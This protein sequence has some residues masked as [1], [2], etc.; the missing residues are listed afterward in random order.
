MRKEPSHYQFGAVIENDG[1]L[2]F[3]VWAPFVETVELNIL[4]PKAIRLP[5]TH[6]GY[7]V[8]VKKVNIDS[9]PIDYTFILDG[10]KER[11]DPA[12]FW[13]PK[14]I[15][16]PSRVWDPKVTTWNDQNWRGLNLKEMIIYE[17]H[18]GTFTP[19]G[20]FQGVINKIPHLKNL[21][22]NTIELMPVATFSGERN[23]GYDGVQLYAPQESYGGPEG[24]KKLVDA[25]HQNGIAVILD[26]VYNHV[27][28][29]GNYLEDFGPYFT[30]KYT[31]P[32]GKAINYDGEYSTFV[33]EF[34]IEN[35]IY[36][37]KQYHIDGLRLD[38]I[39][40][41]FDQSAYHVLEELRDRFKQVAEEEGRQAWLIAESDLNDPIHVKEQ[42]NGGYGLDGQWNDDF[43]HSVHAYLTGSRQ[44]YFEDF[45]TLENI[46]KAL[47]YGFVYDGVWSEYR[48]RIHGKSSVEIPGFRLVDFIQNHDQIA[49]ASH[50][51][52]LASILDKKRY[53]LA[54]TLL[55][56]SPSPPLLFMGQEW[57]TTTPFYFFTDFSDPD[58]QNAVKNGRLQEYSAHG[59]SEGFRDPGT[60]ET[61]QDSTLDW[62]WEYNDKNSEIFD[63]YKKLIAL[64]KEHPALNNCKKTLTHVKYS[65]ENQWMIIERS[66]IES[67]SCILFINFSEYTTTIP[68][69]EHVYKGKP[70]Y[71]TE[72]IHQQSELVS[73]ITLEPLSLALYDSTLRTSATT[74]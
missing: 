43:H 6:E 42:I 69:A 73:T 12:S 8:Y 24:L 59:I 15:N 61:F 26:V 2:T 54:S 72:D 48:K 47:T 67:E 45:G 27:G 57:G 74:E 11:P 58:L 18:V 10:N 5:M 31:T 39:H 32:W 55:L 14:G 20:T 4:S 19:E 28:P 30:S 34:F 44:G 41:I 40:G 36:W 70:L 22:I 17:L 25:C 53:L 16:S 56:L 21:G 62:V 64:R 68:I 9:Y 29:E 66:A 65:E 51:Q 33:R 1:T 38:A 3:T 23:W 35:A 13:Q 71:A 52:R 37:L 46:S 7:G 50:G 60:L 63:H 49:N